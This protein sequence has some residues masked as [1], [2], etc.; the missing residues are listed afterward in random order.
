MKQLAESGAYGEG[1]RGHDLPDEWGLGGDHDQ[2]ELIH[3]D[4]RLVPKQDDV[5]HCLRLECK[6]V[7]PDGSLVCPPRALVTEPVLCLPPPLPKRALITYTKSTLGGGVR[8]RLVSYNLLAEIYATQQA[9]PHC[10]FWALHW[11]Y[12]RTNLFREIVDAQGDILCLQ[13][14]QADAFQDFFQP[15]LSEKGYEGHYKSKT[16]ESMGLMGKV[17]GCALF[18]RRNKFRLSENYAIEFNECARRAA[19][20]MGLTP[21][22]SHQYIHHLSKDN[23]VQVA[24]LEVLQRPRT[25][26]MSHSSICVANT[27]LYSNPDFPDVKLWQCHALLQEL[28]HFVHPRQLPLLLCG[29]FN[30]EPTSAVYELLA[31]QGVSP[32]HSDLA[33]DPYHVLP[34]PADLTHSI[35]LQSAYATVQQIEPP[36]TNYT[37]MFKGTLDYVWFS[38]PHLRPLAVAAVPTENEIHR[39]GRSMP[40]VQASS[41]HILLLTDFQVLAR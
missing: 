14:V 10:D 7:L 20:A 8:F 21:D 9:Y 39:C 22:E 27:H 4:S 5:G 38:A 6:A 25:G 16:R 15:L 23:I 34:D 32:D 19:T 12:R 26:R 1:V 13:E 31:T 18:W 41:D 28:E 2:W 37:D 30:S 33:N 36:Y 24:V 35:H 3:G 29:D 40:N 17:D 11:A